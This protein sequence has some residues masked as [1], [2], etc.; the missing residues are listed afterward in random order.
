MQPDRP[1]TAR[2]T[3]LAVVCGIVALL[4]IAVPV[5][6][7]GALTRP[8]VPSAALKRDVGEQARSIAYDLRDHGVR[9][10]LDRGSALPE[11]A[12]RTGAAAPTAGRIRAIG[13]DAAGA[14]GPVLLRAHPVGSSGA[15]VDLVWGGTVGGE[16]EFGPA[17]RPWV[18]CLRVTLPATAIDAT[19]WTVEDAV[20]PTFAPRVR[21]DAARIHAGD[22]TATPLLRPPCYGTTGFCPGG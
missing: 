13:T 20:C 22:L 4:A 21:T 6:I 10:L 15:S 16:G 7:L 12:R 11:I 17:A 19:A 9:S 18:T 5:L 14:D 3:V 1:A 2:W 8:A